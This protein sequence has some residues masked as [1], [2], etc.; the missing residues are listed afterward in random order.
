[1]SMDSIRRDLSRA[2]DG[3]Y[4][5]IIIGGGVYG[6]M[7]AHEASRAGLSTILFEK[8]DFGQHTSFNSLRIV[9]GGLRYLQNLDIHR[10]RE[11]VAER[12]WFLRNFPQFVRPIPCLMPLYGKGLKRP[13]IFRAALLLNHLLSC[14]CNRGVLA[15]KQIPYGRILDVEETRKVFPALAPDGLK[16]SAVWYDAFMEDSQCLVIEILRRACAR[17]AVA[18]NYMNVVELRVQNGKVS[19]VKAVDSE[20]GQ[21]CEV[22]GRRVVN[23]AGPW[24][25]EMAKNLHRDIPALFTPSLAWNVLFDMR[26]LSDHAVAITPSRPHGQTFFLVPWKG[27]VLAGTGH[28]ACFEYDGKPPRVTHEHL[29][30]FIRRLNEALPG[31]LFLRQNVVHVFS[32]YLPVA[33]MG[34]TELTHREV[35]V[36]HTREG[37]PAGLFSVSGI[38]FT[39]ARRVA[40][41]TLKLLFPGMPLQSDNQPAAEPRSSHLKRVLFNELRSDE[42][43]AECATDWMAAIKHVSDEESVRHL[44]DLVIRRLPL[45]KNPAHAIRVASKICSSLKWDE[46]RCGQEAMRLKSYFQNFNDVPAEEP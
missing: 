23:A 35:I 34:S 38:K 17:G 36:D 25:R 39:T 28:A 3:I 41:K 2:G 16:G 46:F 9:H 8:D 21:S 40:E 33:E 37:G 20:S 5:L 26:T 1:M 13:S 31:N 22:K 10:F 4:D 27:A 19:G 6:I 42:K 30:E 7:L 12:T 15:E 14:N 11:S 18:L 44:D 43:T 24:C 45:A 29:D 32:G